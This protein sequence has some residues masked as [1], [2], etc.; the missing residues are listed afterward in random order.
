[1]TADTTDGYY[2]RVHIKLTD[3]H[4]NTLI[5]TDHST[6]I[7]VRDDLGATSFILSH[8]WYRYFGEPDT[9]LKFGRGFGYSIPHRKLT[10][11]A[12]ASSKF[13][14]KLDG[15]NMDWECFEPLFFLDQEPNNGQDLASFC[16]FGWKPQAAL[17][18]LG[19]GFVHLGI[20]CYIVSGRESAEK[21]VK[22]M[23]KE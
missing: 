14:Y 21:V 6:P 16:T 10:D 4:N 11:G 3:H 19:I 15:L 12:K 1:M 7:V 8:N 9:T 23:W 5:K 13:W 18:S 2:W 17:K 22:E 20:E